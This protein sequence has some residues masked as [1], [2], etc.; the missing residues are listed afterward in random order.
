MYLLIL[1][2]LNLKQQVNKKFLLDN[3]NNV[4]FIY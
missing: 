2:K 4:A 1:Y 3:T